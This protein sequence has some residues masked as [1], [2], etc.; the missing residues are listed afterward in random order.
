MMLQASEWS[1]RAIHDSVAAIA[2]QARYR[3]SPTSTLWADIMRWMYDLLSDFYRFFAGSGIGRT[4]VYILAGVLAVLVLA[5]VFIAYRDERML[6]SRPFA[7]RG[8]GT[9]VDYLREAER[10]AAVGNYTAAGHALFA[11]LLDTLSARGEVRLHSS[12]T[13]GDYQRELR[14]RQSASA[15]GFQRFRSLYDRLVYRDA[16][17]DEQHYQALYQAAL[18]LLNVRKAA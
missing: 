17:I 6:K 11:A 4:I 10:L 13:T 18:P 1:D 12:K 5:R 9:A 7:R 15:P 3:R 16:R 8:A 14:R 2:S